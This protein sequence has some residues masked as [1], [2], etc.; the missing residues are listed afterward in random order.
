MKKG[1]LT[2]GIILL[3]TFA[4]AGPSPCE[5][6]ANAAYD[7]VIN[8]GGSTTLAQAA[9]DASLAACEAQLKEDG[10]D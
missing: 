3:G 5:A 8:A 7:A 2:L 10:W 4:L 1:I 9:Y 6:G